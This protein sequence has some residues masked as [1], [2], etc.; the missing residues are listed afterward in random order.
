VNGKNSQS[1]DLKRE[2]EETHAEGS[3][4]GL[5]GSVVGDTELSDAEEHK[6]NCED[7]VSAFD[8]WNEKETH[9]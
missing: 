7:I 8:R 5:D 6:G 3:T 2:D 1:Q 4:S 9:W